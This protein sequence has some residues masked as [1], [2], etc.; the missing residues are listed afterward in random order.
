MFSNLPQF[1]LLSAVA[2]LPNLITLLSLGPEALKPGTLFMYR[3]EAHG[4]KWSILLVLAILLYAICQSA[5]IY[6][7][8]QSI[9]GRKFDVQE[10]IG[11]GLRRFFPVVGT[12]ICFMLM[13]GLGMVLLVVPAFF[14]LTMFW[15]A[16]PI[17]VVEGLG[18]LKSLGRSRELTKGYRWRILGLW[19]VPV[20][21]IGIGNNLAQ[22]IGLGIGGLPGLAILGF[23]F[24]TLAVAYQSIVNILTY[25]DLRTTKE[26]ADIEQIAAVFD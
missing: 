5:M 24:G 15:V 11:R 4:T 19:F 14:V 6:G 16:V 23:L 8:F 12:S 21:V 25:Q 26:G 18:P 22:R 10:S 13:L 17:C 7:A 2:A 3:M 20:L 1:L 9:R